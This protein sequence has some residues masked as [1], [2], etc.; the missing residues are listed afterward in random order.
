MLLR[1]DNDHLLM[2]YPT[3]LIRVRVHI[4][5]GEGTRQIYLLHSIVPQEEGRAQITFWLSPHT[6]IFSQD[7]YEIAIVETYTTDICVYLRRYMISTA[8]GGGGGCMAAL[9]H[10]ITREQQKRQWLLSCTKTIKKNVEDRY[11]V[12]FLALGGGTLTIIKT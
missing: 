8:G 7:G 2:C 11:I 12:F 9:W 10:I 5:R 3:I 6:N 4:L 1:A